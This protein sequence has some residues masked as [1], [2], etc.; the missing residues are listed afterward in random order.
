MSALP[1][2]RGTDDIPWFADW[3]ANLNF[4]VLFPSVLF[5]VSLLESQQSQMT[6]KSNNNKRETKKQMSETETVVI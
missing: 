4:I 1:L 3:E 5:G 2:K 6:I